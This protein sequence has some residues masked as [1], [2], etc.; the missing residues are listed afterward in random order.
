MYFSV[1]LKLLQL[2]VQSLE[3]VIFGVI[4]SDLKSRT[5][6]KG[7]TI[8]TITCESHC[9]MQNERSFKCIVIK[10]LLVS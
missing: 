4:N 5:T 7:L 3:H 8:L 6:E 10:Q 9:T 2:F 1:L